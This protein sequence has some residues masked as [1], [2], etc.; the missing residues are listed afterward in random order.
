MICLKAG[1]GS[2][3]RLHARNKVVETLSSLFYI[4]CKCRVNKRGKEDERKA[5][6]LPKSK[7]GQSDNESR[8]VE[9]DMPCVFSTSITSLILC[10]NFCTAS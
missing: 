8:G 3:C 9:K 4:R 10:S 5:E 6:A 7:A 2:E 1:E